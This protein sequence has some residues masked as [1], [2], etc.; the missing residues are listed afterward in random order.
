MAFIH[1]IS[2]QEASG[3]VAELYEADRADNVQRAAE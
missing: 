1:T 2:E 3:A